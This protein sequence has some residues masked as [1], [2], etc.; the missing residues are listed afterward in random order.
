[1]CRRQAC[2]TVRPCCR[3]LRCRG[4]EMHERGVADSVTTAAPCST[5]SPPL[6]HHE[7]RTARGETEPR[8]SS[9]T[10]GGDARL[11]HY[12]T[13]SLSVKLSPPPLSEVVTVPC[14]C[15]RRP[16]LDP[17]TRVELRVL[18]AEFNGCCMRPQAATSSL[19]LPFLR[20]LNYS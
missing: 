14:L 19:E 20:F 13:A 17:L 12:R 9:A 2:L 3:Q 1:M 10:E 15:R 4:R 16:P 8:E 7:R 11:T 5:L 18:R 6:F